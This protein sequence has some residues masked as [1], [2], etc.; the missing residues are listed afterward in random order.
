MKPINTYFKKIWQS[1]QIPAL[2]AAFTLFLLAIRAGFTKRPEYLFLLWNLFLAWVPYAISELLTVTNNRKWYFIGIPAWLAFFPNAPYII[3]DFYHL[4][5][6]D[7]AP[8]WVDVAL[9][10]WTAGSG[11]LLGLLSIRNMEKIL[12]GYFSNKVI[13]AAIHVVLFASAFGIYAGRYL[14]WNSWDLVTDPH[15][16]ARDIKQLLLHPA[17]NF[18]TAGITL[19]FGALMT[20]CYII[21]KKLREK[22][23]A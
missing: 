22:S 2:L 15:S 5:Q 9:L 14:R 16:I 4:R 1:Q 20:T 10:F 18:R 23:E 7:Y 13:E 3:T 21:M 17:D 6:H 12:S 8:I 19:T 11:L